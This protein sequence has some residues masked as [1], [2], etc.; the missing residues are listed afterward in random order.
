MII[1]LL[2]LTWNL[3][4]NKE[5]PEAESNNLNYNCQFNT[6]IFYREDA[7]ASEERIGEE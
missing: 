5:L 3:Y 6:L 4:G 1:V 7:K 2:K